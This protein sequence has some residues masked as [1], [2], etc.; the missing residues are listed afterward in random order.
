MPNTM[1]VRAVDK[2]DILVYKGVLRLRDY[3]WNLKN[4][5]DG[6]LLGTQYYR[7]SSSGKGSE[8]QEE[9]MG[10]YTLYRH[11][12]LSHAGLSEVP[13]YR[14]D[15]GDCYL[16]LNEFGNWC[17]SYVLLLLPL[18]IHECGQANYDPSQA[19]NGD[20]AYGDGVYLTTMEPQYVIQ[21][22][23][24]NNW[25]GAAVTRDKVEAY[26]EIQMPNTPYTPS[27]HVERI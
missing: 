15:D 8:V 13:V 16:Y 19:A 2:R 9:C 7:V 27:K 18:H 24:N 4:F 3:R 6:V 25:D 20:A 14:Q 21:T 23:M 10:R 5:D 22:I 26:F 1:A 17:I 11:A 12:V